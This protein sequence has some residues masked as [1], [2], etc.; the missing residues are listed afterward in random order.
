MLQLQTL[1]ATGSTDE[2]FGITTRDG[3]VILTEVF[4]PA[5]VLASWREEYLRI[6]NR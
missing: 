6:N 4:Q 2:I 1:S 5:D 3:A